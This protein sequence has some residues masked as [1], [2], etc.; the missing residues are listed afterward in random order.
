MNILAVTA[1]ANESGLI[2]ATWALVWVTGGLALMTGVL[3]LMTYWLGKDGHQAAN[4]QISAMQQTSTDQIESWKKRSSEQI[5]V[6]TWLEFERQFDSPEMKRKRRDLAHK[7]PYKRE[8]HDTYPEDVLLF[9]ESVSV[10]ANEGFLNPK[11]A[12]CS[13]SYY[14]TAW[15]DLLKEWVVEERRRKSDD[16]FYSEFEAFAERVRDT[17]HP[18]TMVNDFLAEEMSII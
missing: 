10:A 13:F 6:M 3:A 16:S 5:G 9:F 12:H 15:W 17:K 7:L 11:L 18:V 1:A 14:A 4:R 8:R 2:D